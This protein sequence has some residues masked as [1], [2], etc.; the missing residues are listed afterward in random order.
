MLECVT[1]A[2]LRVRPGQAF[3]L[4]LMIF[5]VAGIYL[6]AVL[7]WRVMLRLAGRSG[8]SGCCSP[9]PPGPPLVDTTQL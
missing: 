7:L 5:G 6:A 9:S 2:G 4:D 3:S 1:A 8:S